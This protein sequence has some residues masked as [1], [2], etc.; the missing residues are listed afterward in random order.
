MDV[1][2]KAA[3]VDVKRREEDK[4]DGEQRERG[5]GKRATDLRGSCSDVPAG[6]YAS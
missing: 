3:G 5:G 4:R 1:L 2:E 6:T